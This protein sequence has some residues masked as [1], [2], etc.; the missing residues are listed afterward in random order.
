M[1]PR[2]K[3]LEDFASAAKER[4]ARI[5]TKLDTFATK[6]DLQREL[7]SQTWRFIGAVTTLGLA[8]IGAMV[9]IAKNVQ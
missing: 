8:I 4:L 5:E 2:I 3:A 7:H 9:W 6:E 1:E